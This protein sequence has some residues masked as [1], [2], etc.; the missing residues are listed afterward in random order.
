M[1]TFLE[2]RYDDIMLMAKKICKSNPEWEDVGHFAITE[3][4]THDRGQELVDEGRGMQFLSG[5]MWISFNSST[6]AYHTI[7]R[8]KGRVHSLKPDRNDMQDN[9]Y[10]DYVQNYGSKAANHQDVDEYD[11]EQDNAVEAIQGCLDD[12]MD[13]DHLWFRASLFKMWVEEPNFSALARRTKIP[14]TSIAKA[15]DEAKKYIKEQLKQNGI[16]YE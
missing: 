12:M 1:N 10:V 3:F 15:V 5:I 4:A 8:Q 7:Y 13:Q 2:T 16:D 9:D 14:R 6:S 11:H